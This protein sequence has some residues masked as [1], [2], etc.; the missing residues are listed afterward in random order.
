MILKKPTFILIALSLVLTLVLAAPQSAL[1]VPGECPEGY[2]LVAKYDWS[3]TDWYFDGGFDVITFNE[4]FDA[5]FG[6][7][8]S[9]VPIDVVVMTDGKTGGPGGGETVQGFIWVPDPGLTG[10]Y[11]STLMEPENFHAISNLV[12]CAW[13]FPVTLASYTGRVNRGVVSLDWVTAT[14]INT[15]GFLLYRS[16]TP[17]GYKVQLTQYLI[18]AQGS[19]VAGSS[20]KVT[21]TPGYGTF[22]YWLQDVDHSGF[23]S[24]HGPVIVKVLPAIRQPVYRP[25]LPSQ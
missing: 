2:T 25:S 18:A 19:A 7:W 5:Y 20:Y 23:N 9:T 1:A 24:L 11:D 8:T 15:A 10:Y 13:T 21:D 16:T 12:F 3:A 6:T 17:D 22:Y 14:E 4:P